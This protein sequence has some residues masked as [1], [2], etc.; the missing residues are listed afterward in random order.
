VN[1]TPGPRHLLPNPTSRRRRA[2]GDG[3][4]IMACTALFIAALVIM[5]SF[6]VDVSSW[7][8]Q[9][10]QIQRAADAAALAG[11][12]YMP[13]FTQAT[14]AANAS[15]AKNGY[16]NGVGGIVVSIAAVPGL[17]RQLAV[18]VTDTDVPQ[19]FS[20]AY[21]SAP[22]IAKTAVAEY[23]TQ[24]PL[25]SPTNRLG[26]DPTVTGGIDN[27]WA[28]ISGPFTDKNNGDPF[29]TTCNRGYSSSTT[30]CG[31]G[32]TNPEYRST[33]YLY[34]VD[35]TAAQVGKAVTLSL[36]DANHH[37]R[38]NYANVETADNGMVNTNFEVFGIDNTP[39]TD[40]DNTLPANTLAGKCTSG[41]GNVY[42]AGSSDTSSAGANSTYENKWWALCTM[43]PTKAGHMILQV[44]TSGIAGHS[45]NAGAGWNQYSVKATVATGTNPAIFGIGDL[46]LFNN[47]PNNTL[48]ST[49]AI[50]YLSQ[51]AI[52][53]Q[54]K[55]LEVKLFDPGDG[56]S[57]TYTVKILKPNSTGTTWAPA[58]C[59]Y[60]IGATANATVTYPATASTCAIV[61]RDSSGNAFNG[62]WLSI[63]MDIDYGSTPA[64]GTG[65]TGCWWKV[66][67]DFAGMTA[68]TSPN[69]RTVWSAQ[70]LG[71]PVHIVS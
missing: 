4:Y 54:G 63:L 68:G 34:A 51:I 42:I 59:K 29:S 5:A 31:G 9:T 15:L 39:A 62:Q 46:S 24:V 57:G 11:V 43:T 45:P 23:I 48:T 49:S 20:Q 61:T 41:P 53:N 16:T 32:G 17:P 37:A 12:V 55:K 10:T 52:E 35:I 21:T 50:F 1:K 38:T 47:L 3:G 67:Y 18:T 27:L 25:G 26:N 40:S 6:A 7:Y 69:D 33:G 2:D 8:G 56:P 30:S 60:G 44:K 14:T 65:P 70:V 19:Y 28:S 66:Q 64:C 58:T 36:Y 22:T 13:D 71:D